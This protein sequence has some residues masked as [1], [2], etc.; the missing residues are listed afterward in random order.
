MTVTDVD[1]QNCIDRATKV[2]QRIRTVTN[3]VVDHRARYAL[4]EAD[5]HVEAC[6]HSCVDAKH[7]AKM[8]NKSS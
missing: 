2:A 4:S 5:R 6:I 1:I 8:M 7:I 3:D